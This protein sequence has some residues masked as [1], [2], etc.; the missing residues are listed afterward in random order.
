[1]GGCHRRPE[2]L[3]DTLAAVRCA[4]LD[5]ARWARNAL[6]YTCHCGCSTARFKIRDG[7]RFKVRSLFGLGVAVAGRGFPGSPEDERCPRMA[8]GP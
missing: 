2:S 5:C 3:F 7:A 6:L 4:D 8:I 1:M